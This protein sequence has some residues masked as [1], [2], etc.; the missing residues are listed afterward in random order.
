MSL[1]GSPILHRLKGKYY[2]QFVVELEGIGIAFAGTVN[3]VRYSAFVSTFD[4]IFGLL[5][6]NIFI[7]PGFD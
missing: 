4:T 2:I 1:L 6:G 5:E 3:V 7:T